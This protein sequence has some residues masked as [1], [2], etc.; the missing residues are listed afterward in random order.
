MY[1]LKNEF[2]W[3]TIIL[4]GLFF[5][6]STP[7]SDQSIVSPLERFDWGW[8]EPVLADI[9]FEYD[10]S[11]VSLEA[12]GTVGLIEFLIRKAAHFTIFFIL[13]ALFVKAVARV[14][15]HAGLI[16]LFAWTLANTVAIYDEFHQSLTPERTPLIQDVVLDS[17]GALCGVLLVGGIY[18]AKRKGKR[19]S[20]AGYVTTR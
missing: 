14:R 17:V 10:G 6:S 8:A 16:L 15:L 12:K 1:I 13:G 7:Y 18:L 4:V 2:I 5:S 19:R 3:I 20:R 9:D 11:P